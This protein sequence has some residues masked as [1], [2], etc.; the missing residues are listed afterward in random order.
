MA[1]EAHIDG[2]LD[3]FHLAIIYTETLRWLKDM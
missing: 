2:K 3:N 1:Y